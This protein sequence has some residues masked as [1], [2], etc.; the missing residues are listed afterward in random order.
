MEYYEEEYNNFNYGEAIDRY[1]RV[2]PMVDKELL[3]EFHPAKYIAEGSGV[4]TWFWY[5]VVSGLLVM[6]LFGILGQLGVGLGLWSIY[7]LYLTASLIATNHPVRKG[8]TVRSS[9]K[10]VNKQVY[11]GNKTPV[12]RII[13]RRD[14]PN[15]PVDLKKYVLNKANRNVMIVGTAGQG[16]SKLTRYL[17]EQ[18]ADNKKIIF[19]F[20]PNDEYLKMGYTIIEASK[21]LPNAFRDIEAFVNAFAITFPMTAIGIT[22]QY[23]PVYLR[24]IAKDSRNWEEFNE[25]IEKKLKTTKNPTQQ[26]ALRLHLIN[27]PFPVPDDSEF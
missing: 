2:N 3:K 6:I 25:N 26:S 9:V 11:Y 16:K 7:V 14:I 22:A 8:A 4:W 15:K 23:I 10:S 12:D 13:E 19:S 5:V 20:K 18:F 17:L 1:R 21:S 24:E 27:L